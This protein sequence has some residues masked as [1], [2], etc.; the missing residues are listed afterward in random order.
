MVL[1]QKNGAATVRILNDLPPLCPSFDERA[2]GR[3]RSRL[4]SFAAAFCVAA[5]VLPG[6]ASATTTFVWVAVANNLVDKQ[7][8]GGVV[9]HF[10]LTDNK[11]G[12]ATELSCVTAESG[13]CQVKAE[14]EGGGFFDAPSNMKG[15]ITFEKEGFLPLANIHWESGT[16]GKTAYFVL[17]PV[18]YAEEQDRLAKLNDERIRREVEEEEKL[19]ALLRERWHA[20][21]QAAMLSC[22]T[23]TLCEKM[24]SLTEIFITEHS[25]TR[26][27]MA[28]P[29]TITTYG[30]L[31]NIAPVLNARKIP[32]RGDSSVV[33][34]S[35][36][37]KP[38]VTDPK[39]ECM[40]SAILVLNQFKT[41]VTD[42]LKK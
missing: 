3:S 22:S 16:R 24:F 27:Q 23:R 1:F 31:D 7:P 34:L 33:S 36:V 42:A 35:A 17:T 15:E 28:T 10:V 18:A 9:F 39:I 2:P 13:L 25:S 29:T 26:I 21:E 8:V 4:R 12:K 5:C 32:S 19:R 20:A 41:Y 6:V 37:C 38:L 14:A 11:T 30:P 40:R